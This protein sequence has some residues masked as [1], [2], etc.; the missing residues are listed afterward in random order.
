MTQ[1]ETRIPVTLLTGFL[2]SGKTTRLNTTLRDPRFGDAA[3]IVN[4]LGDIGLDHLLVAKSEDNIVLLNSGCLCCT[5]L[6]SFKDTLAYLYERRA[7][8]EVPA[9]SR[10]FIE[11]TGLADPAPIL[12]CLLRDS[13]VSHY[14]RLDQVVTTVDALLGDS[15]L[16]V[17]AE[18]IKQAA[19]ADLILLTKTDL[20]GGECPPALLSRLKVLNPTASIVALAPG[21]VPDFAPG[22][23]PRLVED[24]HHHDHDS[25][26][27]HSVAAHSFI[28]DHPVG[29]AGLAAWC[30]LVREVFG[31]SLLRCKGLIEIAELKKPVLVQ[32]VQRVFASPERLAEWPS[33]DRR[34]R[35]V[36][37]TKGVDA[38]ALHA[39]LGVL[40]SEPGTYRPTSIA[41]LMATAS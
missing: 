25:R 32:G 20:I 37:I 30:E 39:S 8:A 4:E 35:L 29:W 13:F 6:N 3:V 12:Q 23:M 2:G 28:I 18:A 38:K 14:Y 22:R 31:D 15:T 27:D 33:A 11:T 36:C 7:R 41:E 5:V 17:H 9:F 24:A 16:D 19:V 34:S 1:P 10:V 26:H 21:Q 40:K